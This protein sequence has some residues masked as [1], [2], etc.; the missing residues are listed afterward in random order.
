MFAYPFTI[1]E[2]VYNFLNKNKD[3]IKLI[4]EEIEKM[5]NQ[6]NRDMRDEYLNHYL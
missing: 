3:L 2:W 6:T 4:E 1:R 5:N